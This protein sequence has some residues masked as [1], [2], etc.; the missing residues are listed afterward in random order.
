MFGTAG[1]ADLNAPEGQVV[2][3]QVLAPAGG[4]EESDY[5]DDEDVE[6]INGP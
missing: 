2:G 6:L 1:S 5:S 4:Q 3:E